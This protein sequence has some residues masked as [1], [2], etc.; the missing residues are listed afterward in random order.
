MCLQNDVCMNKWK[1]GEFSPEATENFFAIG[2][3]KIRE[4]H[5]QEGNPLNKLRPP[6]IKIWNRSIDMHLGEFNEESEVSSE[7]DTEPDQ[8]EDEVSED[9]QSENN[10]DKP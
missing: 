4:L 7:G 1:V 8:T 10:Q 9:E 5:K 6:A 3:K 2:L